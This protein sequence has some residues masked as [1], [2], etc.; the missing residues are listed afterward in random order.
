MTR[1]KKKALVTNLWCWAFVSVT[2]IFYILFQGYPIICSVYY[3]LHDWSGMT[4][5]MRYVGLGNF[6]KLIK[7]SMFWSAFANS[8][9]YMFA[10]VPLEVLVSLFYA[11]LLNNPKLRG[12]TFYRA[13]LFLPVVITAAVAGI[14]MSFIFSTNGILNFIL[15]KIGLMDRALNW[16]GDAKLAVVAVILVSLWKD[17]GTYMLYWLAALQGVSKDIIEASWIDGAGPLKTFWYVTLPVIAPTAGV[18]VILC[19]I[20]SLKAF[21]II[22]T[23][24]GGGPFYKT[25]VIATYIY[26]MAF[27]AD[28]G[29][30]RFGYASAA[31]ITFGTVVIIIGVILN[32]IK[33][34][35]QKKGEMRK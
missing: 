28:I 32:L 11:C 12:K 22:Q 18:I 8:F 9:K 26:K 5:N 21:D 16:I 30:P 31:S 19:T 17:V 20:N 3:S 27:T 14:V 15:M 29:M 10:M 23:L 1:R 35:L 25:D 6:S 2:L 34:K 13:C 4:S 7:D 24:T 33:G